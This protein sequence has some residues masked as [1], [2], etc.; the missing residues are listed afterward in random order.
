MINTSKYS[1]YLL[2]FFDDIIYNVSP[3]YIFAS[4]VDIVKVIPIFDQFNHVI[5]LRRYDTSGGREF[6]HQSKKDMNT[7]ILLHYVT[8]I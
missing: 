8:I 3:K 2:P 5:L 7:L 4:H 1:P 6:E